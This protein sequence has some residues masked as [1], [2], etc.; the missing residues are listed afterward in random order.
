MTSEPEYAGEPRQPNPPGGDGPVGEQLSWRRIAGWSTA[1]ALVIL[2]LAASGASLGAVVAGWLAAR[3][4]RR[5]LEYVALLALLLIGSVVLDTAG[6]VIASGTIARKERRLR[7]DLLARTFHQPLVLLQERH[8][9]EILDRIDDDVTQVG[10]LFRTTGVSLSRACLRGLLAW[11]VAGLT[12]PIAWAVLPPVAAIAILVTRPVGRRVAGYRVEEEAAWSAH[13]AQMEEAV[14]GQDDV[15]TSGA[16]AFLLQRYVARASELL[17]RVAA[18]ANASASAALRM[19]LILNMMLAALA[20]GAVVLVSKGSLRVAELVTLWLLASS[21]VGQMTQVAQ[22]L[23]D[24]QAGLGALTRI[25]DLLHSPV[26]KSGGCPVPDGPMSVAFRGL[27]FAF[28]SDGSGFALCDVDLHVPAGT[29]C[30]L[31]GRTG[32]GKSTLASFVSRALDPPAGTTFVG[33]QDVCVTDLEALR[34][35]VGVVTQRTELLSATLLENV[36]LL[37]DF[38]RAKVEA[39]FAALGLVEWVKG[40]PAGLDTLLGTDGVT[41]SAGEQ[42]LVAIARL[43]VRDV[44]VV[45]LDEATA[46]MDPETERRVSRAYDLLLAGRTG[47]VIAHRLAVTESCDYVAVLEAGRIVQFGR[48]DEMVQA[49][50]PF[51]E[52]LRAGGHTTPATRSALAPLTRNGGRRELQPSS[53][54][55]PRLASTVLAILRLHPRW[56]ALGGVC[57]GLSSLLSVYG[58]VTAWLW[59]TLVADMSGGITPWGTAVLLAGCLLIAP[60][61][62]AIAIRSYFIWWAAVILRLRLAILLGQTQ[63]ERL[64]TVS[65]G[66]VMARALDSDRLARYA[67]RWVF[68][69]LAFSSVGVTVALG[70]NWLVLPLAGGAL[71]MATLAAACGTPLAARAAQ[72][73]GDRRAE[74]CQALVSALEAV[75]TI[76]LAGA[77]RTVL[78]H[79]REVDGRRIQARARESRT[80]LLLNAMPS[81]LLECAVLTAWGLYAAGQWGVATALLVATAVNGFSW[82]G[83][84]TAAVVTEAPMARKWLTAAAQ[85]ADTDRLT[86]NPGDVDLVHGIAPKPT[87]ASRVP[88]RVL[89]LSHVTAVHEDGTVGVQDV[90]LTVR[91][92]SVVLVTGRVGAGKS[93]LLRCLAGLVDYEG[94]ILWNGEPVASPEKFLRPRQV[95]YVSQAP[96]VFNVSL[97]DNV[98]LGY[99]REAEATYRMARLTSDLESIGGDGGL[100]GYRGT[101]LSGGQIQRLALARALAVEAE[102]LIADDI[103]SALDARTELELW[104]GL[105]ASGITVIGTSSK[106]TALHLADLVVVIEDGRVV[107]SGPWHQL[108]GWDHLAV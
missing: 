31:V 78:A 44:Q 59:G 104:E 89:T 67:D 61:F 16:Q 37:G 2:A 17:K 48:R 92:G 28:E 101:R 65:V 19:T 73:S 51:Q 3:E 81:V 74:F 22:F 70:G 7:A 1:A 27:T 99:S 42:Q 76:K 24:I 47:L 50:G 80:Q 90:N 102:V 77:S 39:T 58:A 63:Q 4:V 85:L 69:M 60:V 35:T 30:A 103:S 68:V 57:F 49:P 26:E 15:R 11:I 34:R 94:E 25:R 98:V 5:P 52:L 13:V 14:A 29:T 83:T 64:R 93:S 45:V 95:A 88:L 36:T 75:R 43:L 8:A 40:L 96:H 108:A 91:R 12:W 107:A 54:Q 105:R 71:V 41:L 100:A 38:A 33:A 55:R 97:R 6:N 21:F 72:E 84:V 56:G 9:G 53:P 10:T 66:V 62:Q 106:Q 86:A 79:L 32:S 23:P 20:L 82:F 87:E 46:R 18:T